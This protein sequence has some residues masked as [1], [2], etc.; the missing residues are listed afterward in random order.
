VVNL[1]AAVAGIAGQLI[2]TGLFVATALVVLA[3]AAVKPLVFVEVQHGAY[4]GEDDISGWTMT[5]AG[6]HWPPQPKIRPARPGSPGAALT[7]TPPTS[8][9]P[10]LPEPPG[11][12]LHCQSRIRLAR[13]R[14]LGGA[15]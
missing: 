13:P 1:P 6:C 5:T 12:T 7:G 8:S 9:P 3:V 10:I 15:L 14:R 11:S 2:H 4:L